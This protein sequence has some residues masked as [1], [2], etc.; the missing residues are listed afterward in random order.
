MTLNVTGNEIQI[1]NAVGQVKFTSNNKLI[2]QRKPIQTGSITV[3]NQAVYIPFQALQTNDFLVISI[4]ITACNGVVDGVT[5]LLNK[6][7]PA[8]GSIMIDF[9]GR[10]VSNIAAADSEHLGVDLIGSNL[11]FKTVRFN[12]DGSMTDG[13]RTTTLTYKARIW[14]YL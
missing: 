14:S 3:T 12:Y 1:K 13:T 4:T 11:V 6:E 5:S 8:N 9:L 7:L 2:W 10:G